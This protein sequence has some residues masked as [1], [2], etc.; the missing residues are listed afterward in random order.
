MTFLFFFRMLF[1]EQVVGCLPPGHGPFDGP[2]MQSQSP[3]STLHSPQG[4][5]PGGMFVK[6]ELASPTG[7]FSPGPM[8]PPQH[9]SLIHI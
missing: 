8:G 7:H 2:P 6:N 9:L 5:P 3:Q 1:L 4:G